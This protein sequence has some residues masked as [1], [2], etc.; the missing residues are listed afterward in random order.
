MRAHGFAT[1]AVAALALTLG[2]TQV[3][4]PG[5][6]DVIN[7]DAALPAGTPVK[8]LDWRVIS[9]SIDRGSQTMATLFGND[10][11]V[12]SARSASHTEYPPGAVLSL[13]TWK[14]KEDPHWF[15]AR[16]PK[17]FQTMEVVR[18]TPGK[19]GKPAASY[20]RFDGSTSHPAASPVDADARKAYILGMR[21]SVI[22]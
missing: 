21:A 18:V 5:L 1:F 22:P 14:Q 3:P 9:S 15:G 13:V 4:R 7:V 8:P 17:E 6:T 11:A 2:C 20:E 16:I 19:D 10:T 12:D